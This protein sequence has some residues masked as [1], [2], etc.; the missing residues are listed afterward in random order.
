MSDQ[1]F[2]LIDGYTLAIAHT[3]SGTIFSGCHSRR[4]ISGY[5]D[6]ILIAFLAQK[7]QDESFWHCFQARE[8]YQ[9]TDEQLSFVNCQQI[10]SD[11]SWL[12][13]EPSRNWAV[14][15]LIEH[16]IQLHGQS[17]NEPFKPKTYGVIWIVPG[18][19]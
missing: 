13:P 11:R 9:E 7:S 14:W 15:K 4:A 10:L 6:S 17:F 16:Q 19:R 18:C 5:D 8:V 3:D 2:V 1:K 12:L